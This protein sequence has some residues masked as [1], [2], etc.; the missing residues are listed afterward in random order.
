KPGLETGING[1]W[2]LAAVATQSIA[3]LGTLLPWP[4]ATL[5]PAL[6]FCLCMFLLGCMLYLAIIPLIFYRL[7]FVRV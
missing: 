3:V 6:F 1:A 2:L 4:D 7:T 5:G